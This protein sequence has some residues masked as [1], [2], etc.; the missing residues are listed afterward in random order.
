MTT[1]EP[2]P[3]KGSLNPTVRKHEAKSDRCPECG[4]QLDTGYE[5]LHCGYDA[6]PDLEYRHTARR[7]IDMKAKP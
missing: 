4:G 3:T 7:D 6:L 5:C 2:S 1:E